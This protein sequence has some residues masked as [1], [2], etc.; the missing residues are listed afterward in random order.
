[1]GLGTDQSDQPGKKLR[2]MKYDRYLAEETVLNKHLLPNTFVF[3]NPTGIKPSL[4][5]AAQTNSGNL[6][7][8]YMDLSNF[9]ESKPDVYVTKMLKTRD[10]EKMSGCSGTMHTLTSKKGM[11]QIC[12]YSAT[13]WSPNVSLF[14]VFIKC[15]LWLEMYE[16]HLRTGQPIDYY[17]KHQTS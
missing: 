6:Y 1:M 9:P 16:A 11:T 8:L 10:G 4:R 7:T 2:P 14:K 13:Y 12:H 15:R 5:I 17:L 3:N